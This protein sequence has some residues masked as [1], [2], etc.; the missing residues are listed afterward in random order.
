L[1]KYYVPSRYPDAHPEGAPYTKAE[2]ERM[3]GEGN[4]FLENALDEGKKVK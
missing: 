2:I 1:D 4:F 3:L